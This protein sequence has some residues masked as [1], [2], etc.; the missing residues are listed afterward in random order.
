MYLVSDKNSGSQEDQMVPPPDHLASASS[1]KGIIYNHADWGKPINYKLNKKQIATQVK[2]N[3]PNH[4]LA[5][6]PEN[7]LSYEKR[8]QAVANMRNL[9]SFKTHEL[10]KYFDRYFKKWAR[11]N[12]GANDSTIY[13]AENK[14][15]LA[16]S[17]QIKGNE[18]DMEQLIFHDLE[19]APWPEDHDDIVTKN[20]ET[21]LNNY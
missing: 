11:V 13:Y 6:C 18:I 1:P 21:A 19:E 12:Y 7:M 14:I 9:D 3:Q 17:N 4:D 5:Q 16:L 15:I 20:M 8:I 2:P 10:R